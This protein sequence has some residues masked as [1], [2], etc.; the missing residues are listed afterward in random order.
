VTK[1]PKKGSNSFFSDHD[2]SQSQEVEF[3]AEYLERWL[4]QQGNLVSEF[5]EYSSLVNE[6]NLRCLYSFII[7]PEEVDPDKD[8]WAGFGRTKGQAE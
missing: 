8:T 7:F 2:I 6:E 5:S 3:R 1:E 4:G